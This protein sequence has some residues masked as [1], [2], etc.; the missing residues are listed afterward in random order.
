MKQQRTTPEPL[1]SKTV[2]LT[3]GD[4][5]IASCYLTDN[6]AILDVTVA[7]YSL[8]HI[9][10]LSYPYRAPADQI[11]LIQQKVQGFSI[12][13]ANLHL[14]RITDEVQAACRLNAALEK[15]L[16]PVTTYDWDRLREQHNKW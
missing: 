1:A 4:R 16:Q 7:F 9:D 15:S 12:E 10:R 13:S 11:D 5:V 8:Q 2:T 14:S 6:N 3:N